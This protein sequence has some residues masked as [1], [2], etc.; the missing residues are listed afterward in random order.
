LGENALPVGRLKSRVGK[1]SELFQ[2]RGGSYKRSEEMIV[3]S[4]GSGEWD[5]ACPP[6][7]KSSVVCNGK[8]DMCKKATKE[9]YGGCPGIATRGGQERVFKIDRNLSQITR[10]DSQGRLGRRAAG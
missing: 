6:R 4:L 7:R 1:T 10:G 8:V 5:P 2:P 3:G 9:T